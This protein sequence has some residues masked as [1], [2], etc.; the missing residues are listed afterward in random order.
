[1]GTH[2]AHTKRAHKARAHTK[3]THKAHTQSTHAH[4]QSTHTLKHTHTHIFPPASLSPPTRV[5]TASVSH[6]ARHPRDRPT[7]THASLSHAS[8]YA[9]H[10]PSTNLTYPAGASR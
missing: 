6:A 8:M 9:R 1:M 7:L 3:H 4:T 5:R 2:K 10:A